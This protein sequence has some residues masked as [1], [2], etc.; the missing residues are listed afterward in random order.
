MKLTDDESGGKAV[1]E[2]GART[3]NANNWGRNLVLGRSPKR[4]LA[5]IL[6]LIAA[7][8]LIREFVLLPVR[9]E[10]PSMEPN[11]REGGVNFVNRLA[12]LYSKPKRGDVVAIRPSN[13]SLLPP[14][15]MFLKRVIGLPGETVSFQ[16]G[17]VWVNGK[18]LDE[19]YTSGDC[20]WNRTPVTLGP[21]QYY[22]V[23]DNRTMPESQH[24]EGR[25]LL[26]RIVGKVLLCKSLFASSSSSR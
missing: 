21:N 7:C 20:D 22:V 9:V 26:D 5:R 13:P 18:L 10:G 25:A 3:S 2:N 23:G 16:N 4:T 19:P 6:A 17:R 1:M 12:Y 8:V 14:S 24:E 15:V 11:Y